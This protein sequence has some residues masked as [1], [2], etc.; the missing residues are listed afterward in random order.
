MDYKTEL[1]SKS[2]AKIK[3]TAMKIGKEK[4]TEHEE[5][6]IEALEFIIT[7]PKCWQ[8]QSEVIKTLGIT[9]GYNAL[10]ILKKLA[11]Q[12]F[13]STII[14][15]RLG[16]SITLLEDIPN[17]ELVFLKSALETDNPL[18]IAGAC[19]ALWYSEFVPSEDDINTII[20]AVSEIVE[21]EGRIIT[22]RCY[23]A[24]LAFLWPQSLTK[25]FLEECMHSKWKTL[26]EIAKSSLNGK[27]TKYLLM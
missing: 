20:K 16:F 25:E 2:A 14:Y 21:N 26:V 7:K 12:E 1:T 22:P 18:L 6:L 19:S 11:L 15:Q 3:K 4:L 10:P 17:G 27:R 23:I 8:A 5:Y 13:D 9:K 24:A